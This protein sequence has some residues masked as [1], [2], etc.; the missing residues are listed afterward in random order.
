M[1]YIVLSYN[2]PN[3]EDTGNFPLNYYCVLLELI[4]LR[5]YYA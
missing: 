2:R 5:E 1:K 3:V 4:T